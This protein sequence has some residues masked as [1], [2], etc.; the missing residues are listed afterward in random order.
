MNLPVLLLRLLLLVS[1]VLN[2]PVLARAAAGSAGQPGGDHCVAPHAT[3]MAADVALPACCAE[4]ATGMCNGE[5]CEC[6]AAS[7]AVPLLPRDASASPRQDR[8]GRTAS[9][10]HPSPVLPPLIRPPI[11]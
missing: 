11:V 8:P 3:C 5:G 2:A 9:R 10:D 6:S 7:V 1:L 4:T